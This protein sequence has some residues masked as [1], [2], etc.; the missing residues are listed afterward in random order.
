MKED[1]PGRTVTIQWPGLGRVDD[2]LGLRR[3]AGGGR[4]RAG[5]WLLQH[6]SVT[7]GWYEGKEGSNGETPAAP[8]AT[9]RRSSRARK[10]STVAC[11]GHSFLT[12]AKCPT[13]PSLPSAH[14]VSRP[15]SSPLR[16]RL[17]RF[18]KNHLTERAL[19][20][21]CERV[22]ARLPENVAHVRLESVRA[23]SSS[24]GKRRAVHALQGASKNLRL[25][26]GQGR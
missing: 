4:S 12:R 19:Y 7:G 14:H 11:I 23:N 9:G 18:V 15:L 8:S 26:R 3:R 13:A 24:F 2:G 25:G 20:R 22:V 21:V 10:R 17:C 16:V 5:R 1:V 6:L